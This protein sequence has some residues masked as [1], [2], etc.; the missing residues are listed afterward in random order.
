MSCVGSGLWSTDF[1]VFPHNSKNTRSTYMAATRCNR[2]VEF[3]GY[4]KKKK[5]PSAPVK[6]KKNLIKF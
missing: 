5:Q 3:V 6:K 4:K 1:M 2:A